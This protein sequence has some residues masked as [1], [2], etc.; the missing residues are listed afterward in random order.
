[1]LSDLLADS[2]LPANVASTLKII[3]TMIAQPTFTSFARNVNSMSPLVENRFVPDEKICEQPDMRDDGW[4]SLAIYE[5]ESH[6]VLK[7]LN[8]IKFLE[9][10]NSNK[11]RNV[12]SAYQL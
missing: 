7:G 3:S 5:T 4:V 9:I 2:N 6:D 11:T 10:L 1:M 8:S 12:F